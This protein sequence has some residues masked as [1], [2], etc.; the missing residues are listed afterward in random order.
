MEKNFGEYLQELRGKMSLREASEKARISHTYIR[1][2]ELGNKTDPSH[3]T[4]YKLAK[5][6]GVS[7]GHLSSL[8]FKTI[9]NPRWRQEFGPANK[10]PLETLRYFDLTDLDGYI[11]EEF[12]EE[13]SILINRFKLGHPIDAEGR[14]IYKDLLKAL[15]KKSDDI[16]NQ[17]RSELEDML[18]QSFRNNDDLI[19]I[20]KREEITYKGQDLTEDHR[21]QILFE[22]DSI[23]KNES[24]KNN[25]L[26]NFLNQPGITLHGE[27]LSKEDKQRVIDMLNLLFPKSK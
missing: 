14:I 16:I 11:R 19:N 13:V 2:L 15:E 12:V 1:D 3:E 9:D 4:L 20:L 21:S 5:A 27:L 18:F 7:Y 10:T 6:Y 23:T 26:I 22:L 17:V 24:E 25:E 8:K